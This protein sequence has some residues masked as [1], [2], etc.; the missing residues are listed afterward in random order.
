MPFVRRTVPLLSQNSNCLIEL[1]FS[2]ADGL[3]LG[4]DSPPA[5]M[6]ESTET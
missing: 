2:T 4:A 5:N 1:K 6:S 3:A